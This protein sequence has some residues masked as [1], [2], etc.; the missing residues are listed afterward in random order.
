MHRRTRVAPFLTRLAAST[1]VGIVTGLLLV[2]A[3]SCVAPTSAL[4]QSADRGDAAALPRVYVT[5]ADEGPVVVASLI[6]LG[7]EAV[8]LA[9]DGQVQRIAL[10]DVRRIE[11]EGDPR[12][13]GAIIGAV[14]MGAWCAI[15]CGQGL[16]SSSELPQAI[17]V[18]AALGGLIGAVIDGRKKGR[19]TMYAAPVIRGRAAP[20]VSAGFSLRF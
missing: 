14:V 13:N 12:T 4:A 10:T 15:A 8:T 20:R 17:M 9:V 16:D 11:K 6:E 5:P 2:M 1:F 18:N 7:R 3:A 19:T